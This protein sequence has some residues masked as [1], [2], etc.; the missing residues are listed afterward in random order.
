MQCWW[1]KRNSCSQWFGRFPARRQY[2]PGNI[3]TN[4]HFTSP[5]VIYYFHFCWVFCRPPA[6][7]QEW[8]LLIQLLPREY[9]LRKKIHAIHNWHGN[10][11]FTF[12]LCL[13]LSGSS[14]KIKAR[15]LWVVPHFSVCLSSIPM[16]ALLCPVHIRNKPM[17]AFRLVSSDGG[18]ST[19]K[20]FLCYHHHSS[21]FH[22]KS[23]VSLPTKY[24]YRVFFL[25]GPPDFQYQNEKQVA[26]N[27]D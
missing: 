12:G 3:N 27:Q 7:S 11:Y 15:L 10:T 26:A 9:K 22:L 24:I 21:N 25:T 18:L 1:L 14:S 4:M 2:Q 13:N 23:F 8:L 17:W 19:S 5:W 6:L 16:S 20:E